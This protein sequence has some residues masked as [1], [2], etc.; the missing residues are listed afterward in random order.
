MVFTGANQ[1]VNLNGARIERMV[2]A[3]NMTGARRGVQFTLARLQSFAGV[4]VEGPRR[5]RVYQC[6]KSNHARLGH[7]KLTG[8]DRIDRMK[9]SQKAERGTMNRKATCLPFILHPVHP[10]YPC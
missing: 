5:G 4:G 10:V 1:R 8:M 9:K 2:K 3:D 7:R 6:A